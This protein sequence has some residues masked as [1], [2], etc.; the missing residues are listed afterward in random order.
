VTSLSRDRKC[1]RVT[2]CTHSRVV[3]LRLEGNI[4]LYRVD[5]KIGPFFKCV[6]PVYNDVGR[7]SI[8]Q[9]VRLFIRSKTGILNVA[10]FGYSLHKFGETILHRKYRLFSHIP[11]ISTGYGSSSYMKVIGLRSRSLYYTEN[12]N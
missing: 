1:P 6:T 11:Y 12:I 4:V 5:Q 7:R 2:K 3:G 8:Y 10:T 9:N